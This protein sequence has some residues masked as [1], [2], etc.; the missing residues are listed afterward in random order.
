[1]VELLFDVV[2]VSEVVVVPSSPAVL[3]P[4]L[5]FSPVLPVVC[6]KD[7][8][9]ACRHNHTRR[10]NVQRVVMFIPIGERLLASE[11]FRR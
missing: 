5:T 6:P 3:D 1:M 10:K 2:F 7:T 8:W 9:H 4:V 11:Q